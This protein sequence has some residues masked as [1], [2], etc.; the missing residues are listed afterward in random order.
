MKL[1][2]YIWLLA[3]SM[4]FASCDSL[5]ELNVDP[6]APSSARQQEVLTAA[7][8]YMSWQVDGRY[9]ELAYL[10]AQYWTWG[11]GVSLGNAE[12]YIAE[13]DDH[14]NL[15]AR[16]Y[17]NTGAD[18]KFIIDNGTDDFV[19]IAKILQAYNFG[20][21]VDHFGD[22]PFSEA[23]KGEIADGSILSP[24]YDDDAAIYPQ[25]IT[26]IDEGLASLDAAGAGNVGSEDLMF[27]GDLAKWA[28][29]GKSLKLRLLMRQSEVSD[30]G[31]AVR[32]LIAAG[33]LMETGDQIA[34]IAFAGVSGDENP[35][36]AVRESGIGNFYVASNASM[37]VLKDNNDPRLSSFYDVAINNG[38]F[39]GINQGAIDDEPFTA[40]R[41]D[42]SEPADKAYEA[43]NSVIFMSD[44]ETWFLR[45]EAAVKYN[46]GDNDA[47]AFRNAINANFAYLAVDGGDA[48]VDGLAYNSG[49]SMDERISTI[50]IQKWVSFNGLQE[51][52]G[53]IESRRLDIPGRRT[54]TEGVFQTPLRSALPQGIFPSVWLYP[55]SEQSFN[56]S[57][58]A[59]RTLLDNVFWD[60]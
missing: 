42:Y 6:D 31:A 12:R 32:A 35:M 24:A 40:V 52:E 47:M 46:T 14:N 37:D 34:Q 49:G 8:G 2:N 25:L 15:W 19:G 54:F 59:Q 18:L 58:P 45:A 7:Q 21:L 3:F 38:N 4:F 27:G 28:S 56:S 50:A 53:W 22:I 10:W 55:E 30:Q 57:A 29:F 48:F 36:F 17:S 41:E 44:W 60:N 5:S 13:P 23:L 11:P 51:V 9:N 20:Y 1:K 43:A 39:V 26:M 33:G 16:S